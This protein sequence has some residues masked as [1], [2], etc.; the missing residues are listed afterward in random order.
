MV[1]APDHFLLGRGCGPVLIFAYLL[2]PVDDL[3]VELFLDG[4]MVMAV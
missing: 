1:S 3:A 4:D 2:Q